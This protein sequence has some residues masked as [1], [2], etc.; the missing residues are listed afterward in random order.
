MPQSQRD[1]GGGAAKPLRLRARIEPGVRR[2]WRLQSILRCEPPR[3]HGKPSD[4]LALEESEIRNPYHGSTT[5]AMSLVK[6]IEESTSGSRG[7]HRVEP[8]Q[9]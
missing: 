5:H 7:M 9:A 1:Q 4:T 6:C 2:L 3:T 8:Y